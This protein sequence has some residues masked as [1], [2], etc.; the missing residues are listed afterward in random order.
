MRLAAPPFRLLL[1]AGKIYAAHRLRGTQPDNRI[2]VLDTS[3]LDVRTTI[4]VQQEPVALT[5]DPHTQRT[6]VA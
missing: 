6:Y 1:H 2:S 5:Y 3:T 4:T